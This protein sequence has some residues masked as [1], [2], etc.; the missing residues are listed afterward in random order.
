VSVI[1]ALIKYYVFGR[2]LH[3]WQQWERWTQQ[4]NHVS[5]WKH[6]V[7]LTLKR[8]A[9]RAGKFLKNSL[10]DFEVFAAVSEYCPSS[11]IRRC[12]TTP[13]V[14]DISRQR[15]GLIC[16]GLNDLEYLFDPWK[17]PHSLASKI[18]E[19]TAQWCGRISRKIRSHVNFLL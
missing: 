7:T 10:F 6:I 14:S 13:S 16:R 12:V 2:P 3:F 4:T 11:A 1:L 8:E 15:S 17:W 18:W 19:K 5:T 9:Q